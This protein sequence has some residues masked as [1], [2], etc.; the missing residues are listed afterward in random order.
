MEGP[1][2]E[3]QPPIRIGR[4]PATRALA[5][6]L[7]AFVTILL[8]A[9]GADPAPAPTA[10]P[11]QTAAPTTSPTATLPPTP[12]P[13]STPYPTAT[14]PPPTGRVLTQTTVSCVLGTLGPEVRVRYSS[15][16]VQT[17]NP[18]AVITRVAVYSDGMLLADSG[19]IAHRSYLREISFK[20][21]SARLH[22]VR[23]HI[24]TRGAP[25]PADHVQFAQCPQTSG[26]PR[27]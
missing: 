10:T 5:V 3:N 4:R 7:A 19:P 12:R 2:I 15:S 20:G 1:V 16:I 23:I 8:M 11:T 24:E 21:L 6:T 14:P 27:A 9:C 25:Q 13:T 17:T 22:T 18:E 26:A